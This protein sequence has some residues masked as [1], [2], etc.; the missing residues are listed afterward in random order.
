M[1]IYIPLLGSERDNPP[2]GPCRNEARLNSSVNGSYGYGTRL[3]IESY[4][5]GGA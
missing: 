3:Y 2:V 4:R 1:P 5:Q